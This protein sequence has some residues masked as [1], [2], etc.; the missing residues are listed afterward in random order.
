MK[1]LNELISVRRLPS[2]DESQDDSDTF[3]SMDSDEGSCPDCN[4]DPCECNDGMNDISDDMGRLDDPRGD[5]HRLADKKIDPMNHS[6]ENEEEPQYRTTIKDITNGK[7]IMT[8][9]SDPRTLDLKVWFTKNPANAGKFQSNE[10]ERMINSIRSEVPALADHEFKMVKIQS[11]R[12]SAWEVENE[13]DTRRPANAYERGFEAAYTDVER[14]ANPYEPD[15]KE[16][17]GW[18]SGWHDGKLEIQK[19]TRKDRWSQHASDEDIRSHEASQENEED[20][21]PTPDSYPSYAA[22]KRS[23]EGERR[24]QRELESEDEEGGEQEYSQGYQDG[25]KRRPMSSRDQEYRLGYEDGRMELEGGRGAGSDEN[26]E[27]SYPGDLSFK[28]VWND[29]KEEIGKGRDAADALTRLGY[30]GGAVRALDYY[31]EIKGDG[32]QEDEETG[33]GTYG[34]KGNRLA[35]SQE[36]TDFDLDSDQADELDLDDDLGD[37]DAETD[38]EEDPKLDAITDQATEDPDKQGLIRTVKGSHL[39]YKRKSEDGTYEELWIYNAGNMRDELE[40]RKA[41]LAGTDIPT[42]KTQ[43]PDG[44]QKYELWSAGNAEMLQIQ[45]LPN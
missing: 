21:D 33:L 44:S 6:V 15:T 20:E 27:R 45:G 37:N 24:V 35:G 18:D 10:I 1:L 40:V 13:E 5:R 31:Q 26:E 4:C 8:V 28:F 7:Y 34:Q 38:G 29:G 22:R 14:N 2:D 25:F 3:D 16:E 23:W 32:A 12:V 19:E 11:P 17:A 9:R 36:D 41:I 39:V 42:S 30:G 43:S